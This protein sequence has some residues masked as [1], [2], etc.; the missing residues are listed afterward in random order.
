ME[1]KKKSWYP[2]MVVA[3]LW[4]VALLNYMD[5][6]ML[7]TMKPAMMI[8]ISDLQTA[9]NFGRLLAIFL[10]IYG[11]MSPMAGLIADRINR[12][13]LIIGSLGVWSFVTLTMGYASTFNQLMVLRAIM[14]IS[15]ALYIPAGLALIADY[16]R[17]NTRSLA[18]GI[19][20]T[21][22]YAGQAMGGFGAT[23]ASAWS[24]QA[25]FHTFGLI[26]IVYSLVLALLL[27]E[28]REQVFPQVKK[29]GSG[30]GFKSVKQSLGLLLGTISFWI[31][32]FYFAVPS[33]PGW[34]IKN[35][36]PTLFS[37]TLDIDMSGAGPLSTITIAVSS[38]VGVIT[39]G[40][41]ADRWI[42]RNVRGRI[43]TGAIGLSL[44][45]PALFLIGFG[46]GLIS[47][48]SGGILFGIGFGMFDSNN[49]PILCQFV[50]PGHRAAGY[51]LMNMTGVFAGAFI[52]EWL[53]KSTDAGNLGRDLALLAIPVMAALI[54]I[55]T[56]LRPE[57]ADKT[58]D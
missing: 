26:G 35:W 42:M 12:K 25:A 6:Q 52:T 55:L 33:F 39:G 5:R 56:F 3:L 11:L 21:G 37:E 24:W 17:G 36:L 10:W 9:E 19:H 48:V 34:A 32:L 13:W 23:V 50:S 57:T 28:K 41:V 51:G 49:M 29:S 44:T 27:F 40:I 2:W 53:G 4:G 8:D 15:E 54:L 22:L 31:I 43:Y 18:I 38:F 58:E 14:G 1:L 47:V 45:I 20:M 16:H 30:G 46:G 7:S